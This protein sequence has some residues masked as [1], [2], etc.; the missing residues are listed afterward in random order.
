[1]ALATSVLR[2]FPTYEKWERRLSRPCATLSQYLEHHKLVEP[3]QNLE[4]LPYFINRLIRGAYV[5][6]NISYLELRYN[7]YFRLPKGVPDKELRHR[8]EEVVVTVATAAEAAQRD[9]PLQ[10][11]Q[12]L[13]MDSRLP[14]SINDHILAVAAGNPEDVCAVD[15]AGPD[16]AY[17]ERIQEL[18]GLLAKARDK[19]LKVTAHMYETPEGAYPELIDYVDRIGHGVQ[20]PLTAP[21]LLP[22]LAKQKIP[23]EVCPTTYFRTGTFRSYQ[24]LRPVFQHCFDMGVDIVI[25]TDNSAFHGVRLPVEFE[26]LLMHGVINF[27]QM[28]RL[29]EN[30]FR[31]AFRPV[32]TTPLPSA[33]VGHG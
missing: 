32:K 7:P 8:L 20:I 23:L 28:E 9:F 17:R 2:K 26:R 6:E 4:A 24:E 14:H 25:G 12:I 11:T 5:F 33:P 1:M 10:F 21:R 3:L 22:K 15:L 16:E 19:G 29:R 18:I 13:C 27:T 31:Y 30:A